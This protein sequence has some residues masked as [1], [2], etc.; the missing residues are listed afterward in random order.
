MNKICSKCGAPNISNI[1]DFCGRII[2]IENQNNDPSKNKLNEIQKA[3]GELMAENYDAAFADFSKLYKR[4]P[5]E[6]N[7][8]YKLFISETFQHN[9]PYYI[10]LKG[11]SAP[12][13][14]IQIAITK[15]D[16]LLIDKIFSELTSQRSFQNNYW[17]DYE[18]YCRCLCNLLNN[19]LELV[20]SYFNP[21]NNFIISKNII[22]NQ[23]TF[24]SRFIFLFCR[25][26]DINNKHIYILLD[27]LFNLDK[28][29]SSEKQIIYPLK[30]Q[31]ELDISSYYKIIYILSNVESHD[32]TKYVNY[33]LDCGQ[34][35]LGDVGLITQCF[36][37]YIEKV[38]NE[39]E[40]KNVI[41]VKI[42]TNKIDSIIANEF[43]IRFKKKIDFSYRYK[44]T[45]EQEIKSINDKIN[46]YRNK[47]GKCFIAT[48]TMGSYEHPVVLDLRDFR[49]NWL[50]SKDWGKSFVNWYYKN[51]PLPAS[52]I[53]KSR[54]LKKISYYTIVKPLHLISKIIYK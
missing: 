33:H 39:N 8:A 22:N 11:E 2:D 42:I 19:N 48:A 35:F 49:D 18:I 25:Y 52:L 31:W 37:P 4:Y 45:T 13:K 44:I 9:L 53:S 32:T 6:E 24:I 17:S 7:I 41:T 29:Y 10:N 47:K 34:E 12:E 5:K 21:L 26:V 50:L 1:C 30:K 46:N 28:E 3:D 36:I 27:L 43:L 54:L 23:A 40:I 15:K 51:G 14:A 38:S 16:Y 20:T